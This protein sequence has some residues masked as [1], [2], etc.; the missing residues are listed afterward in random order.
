MPLELLR[1]TNDFVFKKLLVSENELLKYVL[2][3]V[4]EPRSP[5]VTA[6]VLNPEISGD[7]ADEKATV[8]DVKAR[9]G[10]GTLVDIEMQCQPH[11]AL[12][13]RLLYYWARTYGSQLQ[14]YAELNACK[15]I[16]FLDFHLAGSRRFHNVFAL[17]ERHT[18][19]ELDA[20]LELHTVELPKLESDPEHNEALDHFCRFLRYAD[21]E[22]IK[23]ISMSDPVIDKARRRLEEISADPRSR[24]LA[25]ARQIGLDL[26][27]H[28][29][30]AERRV[31][32][33]EGRE[34][35]RQ[36]GERLLL[37]R[38]LAAKF[39]ALP[40]EARARVEQASASEL[41]RWAER[42]LSAPSLADVLD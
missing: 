14:S 39:G 12:E 20:A 8:L 24:Q 3:A 38:Q 4:L 36:E 23:A 19:L 11:R 10:D 15:G 30:A 13:R 18:G 34:E 32:R 42:V 33:E 27:H 29:L 25:E 1:P 2:T 37:L 31:G 22:E 21:P 9:L 40:N 17:R 41:E 28:H 26:Y 5:V 35:G 16:F 7:F 6:E